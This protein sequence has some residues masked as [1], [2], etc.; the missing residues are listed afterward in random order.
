MTVERGNIRADQRALLQV[1]LYRTITREIRAYMGREGL[2]QTEFAERIGVSKGY[3]SR[4]LKG[5]G[6][7][8]LSSILDLALAI[9]KEPNLTFTDRP[10]QQP[11]GYTDPAEPSAMVLREPKHT[12]GKQE[13]KKRSWFVEKIDWAELGRLQILRRVSAIKREID[14]LRP[15][16]KNMERHV[17]EQLIRTWNYNSNAIEG[18]SLTHGETMALI[19]HGLT[20]KGKPLKD[21]LDVMGHQDA[22]DLMLAMVKDGAPLRQTD[23]RQLHKVLLKDDYQRKAITPDGREVRRTIRVGVYKREPNHVITPDG[24]KHNYAEP[25]MVPGLMGELVDW[26]NEAENDTA[27]HPLIRA[28]VVHHQFVAIHPFD[29]GNGRTTRIL[30]N[31]TLMR[32]GYPLLIVPVSDRLDYYKSLEAADAGNYAP[33][34]NFL[35]DKLMNSLDIILSTARGEDI[36]GSKWDTVDDDPR[37]DL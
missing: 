9:D 8:K 25:S 7:P 4:L 32:S 18:N 21:H 1:D 16:S 30:M 3:V 37:A 35:G 31:L 13:A 15:F 26:F 10:L 34:V 28:A 29:D 11:W 12:Y 27:I 33:L 2:N 19:L 20:A 17:I 6:D 14:A 24:K 36:G 22:V 5:N 23:I